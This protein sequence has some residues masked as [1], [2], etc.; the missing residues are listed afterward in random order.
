MSEW[1]LASLNELSVAAPFSK[2][3]PEALPISNLALTSGPKALQAEKR[4]LERAPCQSTS[5]S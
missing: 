3:S 2:H 4:Q 5:R 1:A